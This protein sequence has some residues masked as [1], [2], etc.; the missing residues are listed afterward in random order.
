M[1]INDNDPDIDDELISP[2]A[3]VDVNDGTPLEPCLIKLYIVHL[4]FI[5]K[6]V[7]QKDIENFK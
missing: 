6:I 5:N 1:F 2:Y 4:P 7:E 3:R